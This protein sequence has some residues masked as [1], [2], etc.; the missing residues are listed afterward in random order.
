MI[1]NQSSHSWLG[2]FCIHLMRLQP[3]I[4]M[5]AAVRRAVAV[6][7]YAGELQPEEAAAQFAVSRPDGPRFSIAAAVSRSRSTLARER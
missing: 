5:P 4:G 1:T 2:R 3:G 6:Y 7:P